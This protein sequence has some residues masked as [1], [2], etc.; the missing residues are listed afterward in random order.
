MPLQRAAQGANARAAAAAA[1]ARQHGFEVGV[2][3]ALLCFQ[4]ET[5]K[6]LRIGQDVQA[7]NTRCHTMLHV[8]TVQPA[9]LFAV[10]T[11]RPGPIVFAQTNNPKAALSEAGDCPSKLLPTMTS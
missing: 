3:A 11:T 1:A 8:C 9:L 2:S 10:Q 6:V 5:F 4:A 7:G